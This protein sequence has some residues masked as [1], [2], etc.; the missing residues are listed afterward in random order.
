MSV[1]MEAK[2]SQVLDQ[3]WVAGIILFSLKRIQK[4]F[5][6]LLKPSEDLHSAS[7]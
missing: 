3:L 5:K 7:D 2:E 4:K 1:A 6:I